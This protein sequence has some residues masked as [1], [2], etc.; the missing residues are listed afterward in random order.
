MHLPYSTSVMLY[1]TTTQPMHHMT[2]CLLVNITIQCTYTC[3]CMFPMTTT[4]MC[5][6]CYVGDHVI[7]L[8]VCEVSLSKHSVM[9]FYD[10]HAYMCMFR[11]KHERNGTQTWPVW[12]LF[13]REWHTCSYSEVW[14]VCQVKSNIAIGFAFNRGFN[15]WFSL[16]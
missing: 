6:W 14:L 12:A 5:S 7:M 2:T 11:P 15:W 16:Y 4:Y 3:T 9:T 13:H 8:H 1:T 10:Q